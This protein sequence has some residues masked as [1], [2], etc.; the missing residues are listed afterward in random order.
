MVFLSDTP[1]LG[2]TLRT[3]HLKMIFEYFEV[4]GDI[5]IKLILDF[6]GLTKNFKN[7]RMSIKKPARDPKQCVC[8]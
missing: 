6:Q 4:V 7:V 8:V 3:T 2:P 5:S 1:I